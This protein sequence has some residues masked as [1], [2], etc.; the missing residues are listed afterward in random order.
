MPVDYERARLIPSA[1]FATPQAVLACAD[2][3]REQKVDVLLRW[4]YDAAEL[5]VAREEGMPGE[6][7]NL[8]EQILSALGSLQAEPDTEQAGPTKQHGWPSP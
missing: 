4:A 2:L 3:T 6:E 8:Q 1:V 5:A 7:E